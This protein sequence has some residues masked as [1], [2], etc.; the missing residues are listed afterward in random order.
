MLRALHFEGPARQVKKSNSLLNYEINTYWL[1]V[2]TKYTF[3]RVSV[4]GGKRGRG[5]GGRTSLVLLVYRPPRACLI[6]LR[7]L[8]WVFHEWCYVLR[9]FLPPSLL[10]VFLYSCFLSL[11]HPLLLFLSFFLSFFFLSFLLSFLLPLLPPFF[12]SLFLFYFLLCFFPSFLSLFLSFSLS[13][14]L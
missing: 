14:F 2:E 12:F 3:L 4:W 11:V 13:F 5:E 8:C 10:S 1:H 6:S 9:V 7:Q